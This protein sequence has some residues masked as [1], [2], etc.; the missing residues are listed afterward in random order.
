[1]LYPPEIYDTVAKYVADYYHVNSADFVRPFW[2]GGD[3]ANYDYPKNAIVVDNPP[4]SI[5]G[6]I[7]DFYLEREIRFFLFCPTTNGRAPM[8]RNG[9]CKVLTDAKLVYENG[10][11]VSTSFCTNM[12]DCKLRTD[13]QLWQALMKHSYHKPKK[14][15]YPDHVVSS[16]GLVQMSKYS[17][18]KIWPD[19]C[20]YIS[21]LDEMRQMKKSLFGGGLLVNDNAATRVREAKE[22]CP[23]EEIEWHLSEREWKLVDELNQ[24]SK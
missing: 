5:L 12:D 1:M 19:E 17:E 4:F 13:P 16:G 3:Y 24:K 7:L 6:K 22:K 9:V 8:L 23:S 11:W 18:L 10:V 21:N 14:Y 2:P 20:Q 15:I